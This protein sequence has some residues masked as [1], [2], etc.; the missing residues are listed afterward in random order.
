MSDSPHS[1]R[2]FI[3]YRGRGEGEGRGWRARGR[4]LESSPG[5]G[6]RGYRARGS[7]FGERPDLTLQ[8]QTQ[9]ALLDALSLDKIPPISNH[10]AVKDVEYLASYNWLDQE[11]S[12]ILIPGRL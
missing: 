4:G 1:S 3:N 12:T 5:R 10:M 2:T 8:W 7:S 6:R 9:G 11:T